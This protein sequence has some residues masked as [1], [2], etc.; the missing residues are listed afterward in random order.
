MFDSTFRSYS[1]LKC[2]NLELAAFE[3]Q[4]HGRIGVTKIN[5]LFVYRQVDP[6]SIF[7]GSKSISPSKFPS[8]IE[9]VRERVYLVRKR[10]WKVV[11]NFKN[12]FRKRPTDVWRVNEKRE[13]W[14]IIVRVRRRLSS[15]F[16]PRKTHRHAFQR[17]RTFDK[18][19]RARYSSLNYCQH[20]VV[21]LLHR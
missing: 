12:N 18:S 9:K 4:F 14:K 13:E 21:A 3:R 2:S 20:A 11:P 5:L 7:C 17:P 6:L 19:N 8:K 15:W 10:F 16:S 1:S